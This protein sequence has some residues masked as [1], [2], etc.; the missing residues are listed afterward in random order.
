MARFMFLKSKDAI[1]HVHVYV[2]K[3][4]SEIQENVNSDFL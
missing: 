1:V 3:N 2:A 4:R